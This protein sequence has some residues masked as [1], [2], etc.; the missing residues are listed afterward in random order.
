MVTVIA[1]EQKADRIAERRVARAPLQATCRER[2][3]THDRIAA[4]AKV[5]RPAVVLW[6]RGRFDSDKIESAIT[7]LLARRASRK[8]AS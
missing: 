7:R 1:P 4:E 6:F 5:T 8:K 2:R 3:I